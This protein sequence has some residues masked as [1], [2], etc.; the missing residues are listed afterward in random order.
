M[1]SL[2]KRHSGLTPLTPILFLLT[3]VLSLPNAFTAVSTITAGGYH[4]CALLDDNTVKCWGGNQYG[5][6]GLGDT[7]ARGVGPN[8]MSDNLPV[9][10][11]GSG[12]TAKAIAIGLYQT[13]A[14]LDDNTVKCWGY[15][16]DGELGLGDTYTRGD[17]AGEVG[18][19]LPAVSLGSG[20]TAKAVIAGDCR[21]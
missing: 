18:D 9:V 21:F 5:S 4:T 19:N 20:R 16:W 3:I 12:R 15:N 10:S 11:L 6:L 17:D 14:L 1:T 2:S 8:E 13:C 7:S